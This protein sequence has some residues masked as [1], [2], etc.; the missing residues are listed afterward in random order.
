MDNEEPV[1]AIQYQIEQNDQEQGICLPPH[2]D[3]SYVKK[4]LLFH[5]ALIKIGR[6]HV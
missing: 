4:H 5:K 3:I 2:H 1:E 6:A